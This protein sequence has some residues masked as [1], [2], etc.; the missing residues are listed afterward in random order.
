MM[1][2]CGYLVVSESCPLLSLCY[3]LARHTSMMNVLSDLLDL[4]SFLL[5]VILFPSDGPDSTWEEK[6]G[7][8]ASGCMC[9][10]VSGCVCVGGGGGACVCMCVFMCL[11]KVEC[12]DDTVCS[13][14]TNNFI[15]VSLHFQI[16]PLISLN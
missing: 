16:I 9:E 11:C 6:W 14:I 1:S 7:M 15:L 2:C 8:C 12:K 4:F 10:G 3:L 13:M 5:T